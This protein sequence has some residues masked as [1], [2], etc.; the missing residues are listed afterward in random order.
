MLAFTVPTI[1][2]FRSDKPRFVPTFWGNLVFF[3]S[4]FALLFAILV[5]IQSENAAR[6]FPVATLSAPEFVR[7]ILM[8]FDQLPK[9]SLK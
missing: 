9:D 6:N 2:V 5:S 1:C 8:T 3:V 4:L 7:V